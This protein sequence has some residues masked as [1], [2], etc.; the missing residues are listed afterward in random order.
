MLRHLV[1]VLLLAVGVA[2]GAQARQDAAYLNHFVEVERVSGVNARLLWAMAKVES[3][4]SPQAMNRGHLGRTDSYDIGLMQ[5]N[6]RWLPTLAKYG[7]TETN[8]K[9]PRTSIEVGAWILRDLFKRHGQSWEAVG[10]YNAACTQ[11]KGDE[12]RKARDLYIGKVK[13]AL[14]NAPALETLAPS[15]QDGSSGDSIREARATVISTLTFN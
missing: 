3:S 10:A 8:L 14:V 7:I 6:S 1:P 5:I 9:H 12:C 15:L 11:L 2:T 4:H 13:Q